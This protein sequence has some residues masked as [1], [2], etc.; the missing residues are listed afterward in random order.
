VLARLLLAALLCAPS[1]ARADE[2]AEIDWSRR[3]IKARGQGAPDLAAASISVARLGAERAAKADAMR[4]I[5]ELIKG[6]TVENGAR[7]GTLLQDDKALSVKVDGALRGFHLV[8][9]EP[10]KP[11]PH[12]YSD[13]GVAIDVELAIDSLPPELSKLLKP[14]EGVAA[15]G[16]VEAGEGAFVI[17]ALGLGAPGEQPRLVDD[18]G[19]EI[20]VEVLGVGHELDG[21][22]PRA[23]A[24]APS[25]RARKVDGKSV[26]VSAADAA[27][28]RAAG[29]ARVFF[30]Y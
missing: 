10:G 19:A 29:T 2:K 6:P 26:I 1:L 12:Y 5:L 27:R 3:V 20:A 25:I 24:D 15:P 22:K 14:P 18:G 9:A 7:I 28:L 8:K 13:G 11:N 21:P 30:V 4:N 16:K 17:D 23:V